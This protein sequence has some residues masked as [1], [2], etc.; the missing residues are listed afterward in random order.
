VL[1]GSVG[2]ALA[3]L[4]SWPHGLAKKLESARAF[5]GSIAAVTLLGL[6]L[7]LFRIS[8]I[9]ALFWSAV[10]NGVCAGPIMV[11]VMLMTTNK[12]ITGGLTFPKFQ[13]ILGWVS[14]VVML[15]VAICMVVGFAFP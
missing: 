8:P 1:A 15:A 4:A 14:T 13:W 5:Y 12:S 7:N 3:E 6:V 11:L 10:V 9:K 2:Y